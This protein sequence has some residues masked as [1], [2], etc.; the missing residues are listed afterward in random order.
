MTQRALL[1][2][3]GALVVIDMQK[4]MARPAPRNNP[5]A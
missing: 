2:R 3:L 1:P 5:Y 4:G